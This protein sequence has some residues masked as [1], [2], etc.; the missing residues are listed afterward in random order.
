MTWT[1]GRDLERA[2]QHVHPVHV[3]HAQVGEHHVE[4]L[5]AEPLQ[6]RGPALGL[7]HLVAGLAQHDGGGDPHVP[8]V[9]DDQ[10]APGG[11]G[12]ATRRWDRGCGHGSEGSGAASILSRPPGTSGSRSR[13][14][15]PPGAGRRQVHRAAVPLDDAAHHRQAEAGAGGLGGEEGLE[16]PRAQ[17]G[18]DARARSRSPR[19]RAQAPLEPGAHGEHA[20]RAASTGARS[21]ARLSTACRTW[22][23]VHAGRAGGSGSYS[24][25]TSTGPARPGPAPPPAR[26][27]APGR[28]ARRGWPARRGGRSRAGRRRCG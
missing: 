13:K 19:P 4:G 15:A 22:C 21:T 10:H 24:R 6:R 18:G 23:G 9:V 5:G 14:V 11:G 3:A 27:P 12:R 26:P 7:G 8:L 28:A 16:D 20:R 25:R 17:L 2:A 1:D